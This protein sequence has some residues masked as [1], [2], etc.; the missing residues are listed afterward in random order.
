MVP[1]SPNQIPSAIEKSSGEQ[2]GNRYQL[3][4]FVNRVFNNDNIDIKQLSVIDSRYHDGIAKLLIEKKVSLGHYL[5]SFS[6][7][8]EETAKLLIEAGAAYSVAKNISSFAPGTHDAIAKLLIENITAAGLIDYFPSFSFT[9]LTHDDIAKLIIK[10]GGV[11][12]SKTETHHFVHNTHRLALNLSF[13]KNLSEETAKLLIDN[14]QG[15]F[16][17]Q[18]LSSFNNLSPQTIQL[19]TK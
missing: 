11:S 6:N 4:E 15:E 17:A 3:E 10:R 13:F 19:L 16:V 2:G 7:L 1:E 8:S 12:S 5:S 9:T 14:G 18:N